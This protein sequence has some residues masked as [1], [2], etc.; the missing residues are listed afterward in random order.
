M[1]CWNKMGLESLGFHYSII[2]SILSSLL[3]IF[4][5]YLRDK[6]YKKAE[7][8]FIFGVVFIGIS[9]SGIEWSLY[10]MGYNL[11]QL[12]TMP[13]FPLLCYFIATSVFIIYLSER[14]FRRILWII[15]A[16]TAVIISIIAVNCMNCLFE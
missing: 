2:S 15:F 6:D 16:A 11:F 5:L 3:I 4:S 10:L 14:Y 9:W 12:V 7:E 13:I 1:Q 8:L